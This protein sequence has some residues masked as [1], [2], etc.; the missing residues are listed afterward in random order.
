MRTAKLLRAACALAIIGSALNCRLYFN[1]MDVKIPDN[2][3]EY[4]VSEIKVLKRQP[5]L[6]N[7]LDV[8]ISIQHP[9][10]SELEA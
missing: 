6:I 2:A 7:D 10:L 1:N 5:I 8:E 4:G 9:D 3:E